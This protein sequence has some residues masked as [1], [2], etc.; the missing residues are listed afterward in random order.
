M[1]FLQIHKDGS[2]QIRTFKKHNHYTVITPN[3][4]T[5]DSLIPF[6]TQSVNFARKHFG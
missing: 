2:Q 6:N 5:S 4:V 3:K 1:P